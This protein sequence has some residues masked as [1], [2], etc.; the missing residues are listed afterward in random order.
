MEVFCKKEVHENFAI[1]TWEHLCWCLFPG[2]QAYNFF[3]RLQRRCFPVN[4]AKFL[5]ATISKNIWEGFLNSFSKE[6]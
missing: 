1:F 4:I 6:H 5:R 2:L 3:K